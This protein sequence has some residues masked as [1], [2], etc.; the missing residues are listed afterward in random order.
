MSFIIGLK[1][2]STELKDLNELF[3]K[4][5]T[6][7]DGLLSKDEIEVGLKNHYFP[8]SVTDYKELFEA[9]DTDGSGEVDY[10]EFITAAIE[11]QAILNIDNLQAAFRIIDQDNSGEI[12]IDELK[13]AFDT[14]GSKKDQE[15]WNDIMKEVD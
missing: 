2:S 7:K 6:S 12:T 13:E 1:A 5:D 14:R 3:T 10:Q 8:E 15:L 4:L 9:M 11:K